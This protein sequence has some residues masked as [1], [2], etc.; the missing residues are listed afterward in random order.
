MMYKVFSL[1]VSKLLRVLL[2]VSMITVVS[3]TSNSTSAI[4]ASI[5]DNQTESWSGKPEISVYRSPSCSCCGD[6]IEHVK[7]QGF[8]IKEDIKTEEMEAIKQKYNLPP[9]LA[10]CHTAIIGGY[11][12]EGHVPADDIKRLLQQK[13]QVAGLAVPAMPIGTPGMEMGNTKQPFA[14]IAFN[15]KGD[16][17]V[18]KQYEYY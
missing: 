2:V 3:L 4:A 8:K 13:S 12:I 14:V 18:F 6:W 10:S 9:E 7:K 11:V 15:K 16:V 5:W 1:A 17:R